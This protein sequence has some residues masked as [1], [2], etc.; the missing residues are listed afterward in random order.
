VPTSS[1]AQISAFSA[2]INNFRLYYHELYWARTFVWSGS[3]PVIIAW[4]LIFVKIP[5]TAKLFNQDTAFSKNVIQYTA[6]SKNVYPIHSLCMPSQSP[7]VLA[8]SCKAVSFALTSLWVYEPKGVVTIPRVQLNHSIW[9]RLFSMRDWN[10]AAAWQ[11]ELLYIFIYSVSSAPPKLHIALSC[12]YKENN[13]MTWDNDC[14]R[15]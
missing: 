15:V 6:F 14:R 10:I 8:C 3:R 4:E 2:A 5:F 9:H 1:S 13:A 11:R 12:L 7:D